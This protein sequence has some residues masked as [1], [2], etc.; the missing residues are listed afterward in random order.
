MS[1]QR[2]GDHE[3]EEAPKRIFV[4]CENTFG[5]FY[6]PRVN[7]A[8]ITE[9]FRA[10]VSPL[11][12][13]RS[14]LSLTT[15]CP[16]KEEFFMRLDFRSCLDGNMLPTSRPPIDVEFVLDISGSMSGPFPNDTDS[17]NKLQIAK[18]CLQKIVEQLLPTDRCGV[19][20]FNDKAQTI[21]PLAYATPG[22]VSQMKTALAS[23][24]T[25][26]GTNLSRGLEHGYNNLQALSTNGSEPPALLSFLLPNKKIRD[27]SIRLRRVFF[28]TDMES[29]PEDERKVIALAEEKAQQSSTALPSHLTIVGIG[30]D[31]SV[32]TVEKLSAIPG[33][34]YISVINADEFHASVTQDFNYDITPLAFNIEVS[35]PVGMTFNKIFGSAELNRLASG[36][37]TA[38]ISSEFPVP[39]DASGSQKGG[40]YLCKLNC[41]DPAIMT[42]GAVMEVTW[43]DL[44]GSRQCQQVPL[45]FPPP[46][47][48]ASG[49]YLSADCDVGLRKAIMLHEYVQCLTDYIFADKSDLG[50][51]GGSSATSSAYSVFFNTSSR[52]GPPRSK[53]IRSR[54][55]PHPPPPQQF[56]Q[57]PASQPFGRITPPSDVFADMNEEDAAD[58]LRFGIDGIV[59]APTEAYL[60]PSMPK[61]IVSHYRYI[62][63]FKKLRDKLISELIAC[64]D[65]SLRYDNKNILETVEQ[66]IDLETKE[67]KNLFSSLQQLKT[68]K[69]MD[70]V[71]QGGGIP[72][73]LLCPITLTIMR[74]PVIAADGHSYERD[75]IT[76]WLAGSD[77]SPSTSMPLPHKNLVPNHSL[78]MV[79]QDFLDKHPDLSSVPPPPR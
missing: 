62:S 54:H 58:I 35:L 73:G 18:D 11:A 56:M 40:I 78:K 77:L 38:T 37:T 60:P 17:R 9:K 64:G 63:H 48:H 69:A 16:S 76:R 52:L 53:R 61:V 50:T 30:V 72:R 13:Y 70:A 55:T 47:D 33:A 25:D 32:S 57:V 28:L 39:L 24:F 22:T 44:S 7:D 21:V 51:A 19:S 43:T 68:N 2:V 10:V 12:L 1:A 34:K 71:A 15:D 67:I 79:C 20:T 75:A 23:V 29:D 45:V 41:T 36:S 3:G 42:T 14:N 6:F 65:M 46:L 31:L 49:Q 59:S 27:E 66:V 26:G 8:L 4:N 5:E 74:D